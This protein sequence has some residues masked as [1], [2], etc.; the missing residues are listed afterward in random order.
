MPTLDS[1]LAEIADDETIE[2]ADPE[3]F[4]GSHTVA[5]LTANSC[6]WPNGDP[7]DLKTFRYC[8]ETARGGGPYCERHARIAFIPRGA[9]YGST[10]RSTETR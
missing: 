9:R 1:D 6:R 8:G 2:T 10:S 5:D 7:R 4:E 3:P